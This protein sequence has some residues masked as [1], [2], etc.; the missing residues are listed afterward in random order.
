MLGQ[1]VALI[2]IQVGGLCVI[3]IVNMGLYYLQRRI[4]LKDQYILQAALNRDTNTDFLNFLIS[5]Y[6]FTF[7]VELL[8]ASVIMI[9]FVPRYGW[10]NGTFNAIFLSYR[11]LPIQ[12]SIMWERIIWQLSSIIH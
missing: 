12:V 1:V 5:F 2:M 7:I 9:D 3:T 8:A 6:R 10:F 11:L 4:P